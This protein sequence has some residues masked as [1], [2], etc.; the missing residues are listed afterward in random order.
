MEIFVNDLSFHGQFQERAAFHD[1]F[2]QVMAMRET[3]K[4]FGRELH[5]GRTLLDVD[6]MPG[7]KMRQALQSLGND[8]RRSVMRW[9]TQGGPFW[10]DLRRHGPDDWLECRGDVVT[11]SAIGEAA[12]RA[13]HRA[14]CGL[15]SAVP[16]CWD[17]SPVKVVWKREAEELE[18]R[19]TALENWRD[20]AALENR[21]RAAEPPIRS[22][23]DLRNRVESR[24]SRLTFAGDCFE[25]LA[26]HPFVKSAAEHIYFL[27]DTL[28]QLAS[29]G[30]GA[31]EGQRI[32]RDYFTGG[33]SAL[34]TDSSTTEKNRR[35]FRQ[36][37]TFPHPDRPGEHLCCT[38]HGKAN[39]P[40]FPLRLH[41][42]WSRKV[43]EPVYVVYIGPKIT[44]R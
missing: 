29:T 8:K 24:F 43:G 17:F 26:G 28:D 4:R 14:A 13:L 1:A 32:Y 42:S 5:G 39:Y 7:M 25:P 19:S 2:A 23:D 36:K 18:D 34:F 10:D 22:W 33:D 37:L 16:S 44:R 21:L 40:S 3:A 20:V 31:P 41:Y 30:M 6:A 15:V 27:L 11:D 12:Y 9:L 35:V 38:W